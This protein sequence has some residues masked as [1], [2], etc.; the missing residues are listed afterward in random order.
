MDEL[1]NRLVYFLRR[2]NQLDQ[3]RTIRPF[4]ENFRK[5]SLEEVTQKVETT[6]AAFQF[7]L[8]QPC[9]DG[10]RQRNTENKLFVKLI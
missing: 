2:N 8:G 3:M 7:L 5:D 4:L 10:E 9:L 6:M 1:M